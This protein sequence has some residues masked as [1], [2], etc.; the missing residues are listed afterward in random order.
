[1]N[2]IIFP[3]LMMLAVSGLIRFLT[4]GQIWLYAAALMTA[5]VTCGYFVKLKR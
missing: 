2:K 5:V 3:I 4:Y 1:M